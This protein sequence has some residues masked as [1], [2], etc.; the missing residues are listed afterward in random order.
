MDSR[1]LQAWFVLSADMLTTAI[2]SVIVLK[3]ALLFNRESI[4][5]HRRIGSLRKY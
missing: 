3:Y 2:V 5:G 4:A 1:L